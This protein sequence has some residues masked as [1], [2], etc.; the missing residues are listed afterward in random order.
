MKEYKSNTSNWMRDGQ[1]EHHAQ[2]AGEKKEGHN[3]QHSSAMRPDHNKGGMQ[4]RDKMQ[5]SRPQHGSPF[6]MKDK[7][8]DSR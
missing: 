8:R 7:R 1:K 4:N 3:P 5:E 6:G 2:H